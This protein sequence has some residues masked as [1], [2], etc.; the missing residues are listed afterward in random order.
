MLNEVIKI[1]T[2]SSNKK[3]IDCTFGAGGYSREILK[4]SNNQFKFIKVPQNI[5]PSWMGLPILLNEVVKLFQN[6]LVYNLE[7]L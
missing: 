5:E 6:N 1:L 3:I 4:V 7:L 2:P